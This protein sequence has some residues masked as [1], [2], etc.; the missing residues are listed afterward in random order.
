MPQPRRGALAQR[1]QLTTGQGTPQLVCT[2]TYPCGSGKAQTGAGTS[3]DFGDTAM[4]INSRTCCS[5][6]PALDMGSK[7]GVNVQS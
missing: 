7:R 5:R 2:H 4:I 1:T 6:S 3:K